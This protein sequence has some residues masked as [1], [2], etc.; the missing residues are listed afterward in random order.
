MA[1]IDGQLKNGDSKIKSPIPV[2]ETSQYFW[3]LNEFELKVAYAIL[4]KNHQTTWEH[5][6]KKLGISR[7][8]L[9]NL[10]Q[11][12]TIQESIRKYSSDLLVSDLP[13]VY[14]ALVKKAKSGDCSAMKLFF[15]IVETIDEQKQKV[16]ECRKGS[17]PLQYMIDRIHQNDLAKTIDKS[18]DNKVT[19]SDTRTDS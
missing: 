8:H 4:E 6:A 11:L 7:R 16:T 9:Y 17:N 19:K 15:E 13:D 2:P 5:V 10:R 12:K 18:S 1:R 3:R 14:K